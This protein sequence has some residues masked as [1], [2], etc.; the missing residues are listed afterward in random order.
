VNSPNSYESKDSGPSSTG[1]LVDT[2]ETGSHLFQ[3]A[4]RVLGLIQLVVVLLML[5]V[6][7]LLVF[8]GYLITQPQ[9]VLGAATKELRDLIVQL[10]SQLTPYVSSFIRL[11]APVFV[12]LFA[13]GVLHRLREHGAAPFDTSRLFADLPSVLALLIIITICLL[14]L[15]GFG[16]PDVLNNVA[17]V[18]VGFYFGRRRT[19][20]E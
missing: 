5:I 3:L 10:W 20:S 15:T 1:R 13:M 11:V 14:P 9:E 16:I 8:Y 6:V 18:V 12:L 2:S 17:L 4:S 7:G 19:T